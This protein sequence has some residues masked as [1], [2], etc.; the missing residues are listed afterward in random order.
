MKILILGATGEIGHTVCKIFSKNYKV[1]SL[2]RENPHLSNVNFFDNVLSENRCIFLESFQNFKSIKS[3]IKKINPDILINCL[4]V[5]KHRKECKE[6]F[7]ETEYINSTLPHLLAKACIDNNIRFIH[8]STDCVFSGEKGN[9]SES[10]TPDPKDYYG[11]SK[12][13]GEVNL[14]NALTLRT[15]FIGPALFHKTGLFEWVKQ[16]K[17][18]TINGYRNAIYSGLTTVAFSNILREIIENYPDLGGLF[19]ISSEPISKFDLIHLLNKKF[20][21]NIEIKPDN[22]FFCDRSLN[23]TAF[24]D[25]TNISIPSWEKMIDELYIYNM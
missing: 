19:H 20:E 24:R 10:D 14:P 5:V 2:M 9:Y 22:N 8:L 16:Q 25:K 1:F 11:Q 6:G 13:L 18:Q 7:I 17:N 4:G 3:E 12:M 23:S 21:L 15:S